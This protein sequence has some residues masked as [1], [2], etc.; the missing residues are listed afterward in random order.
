MSRVGAPSCRQETVRSELGDRQGP[1]GTEPCVLAEEWGFALMA[2]RKPGKGP[3]H[4][5]HV[6]GVAIRENR[7]Q[8]RRRVDFGRP[9]PQTLDV[10]G[11]MRVD[12]DQCIS[13]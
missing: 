3:M 5:S 12:Q 4:R 9:V 10:R 11:L 13:D 7:G 8:G 6:V 1:E 2:I